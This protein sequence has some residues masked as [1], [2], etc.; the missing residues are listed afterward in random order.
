[1]ASVSSRS[2]S[3]QSI[4]SMGEQATPR[5]LSEVRSLPPSDKHAT[6]GKQV[7]TL[8]T[9]FIND[10]SARMIETSQAFFARQS[11]SDLA[12]FKKGLAGITT[13]LEGD[14]SPWAEGVRGVVNYF[15]STLLVAPAPTPSTPSRQSVSVVGQASS[16]HEPTRWIRHEDG[17]VSKESDIQK[18]HHIPQAAVLLRRAM[19]E[20][21][22]VVA[23]SNTVT[24]LDGSEHKIRK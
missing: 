12:N 4:A 23:N 24:T 17:T 7:T 5:F 6:I 14:N 15:N 8:H 20:T 13:I 19:A 1:M 9:A 22:P 3:F 18:K 11:S 21:T 2:Q 16:M 10:G